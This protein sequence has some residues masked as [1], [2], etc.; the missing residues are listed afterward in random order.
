MLY[1]GPLF[2]KFLESGPWY[3]ISYFQAWSQPTNLGHLK[4]Q[5]NN[6]QARIL[7]TNY[8]STNSLQRIRENYTTPSSLNLQTLIKITDLQ[9]PFGK[10]V[11]KLYLKQLSFPVCVTKPNHIISISSPPWHQRLD[12]WRPIHK[13]N[14]AVVDKLFECLYNQANTT[15]TSPAFERQSWDVW[16]HRRLQSSCPRQSLST[17]FRFKNCYMLSVWICSLHFEQNSWK[18]GLSENTNIV[19]IVYLNSFASQFMAAIV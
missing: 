13:C 3:W 8:F 10:S 5:P 17:L 4:S 1:S 11:L 19:L 15:I 18:L 6:W 9:I 14:V 16:M 12:P 7:I 2:H